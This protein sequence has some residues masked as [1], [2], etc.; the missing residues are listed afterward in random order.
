MDRGRYIK[1]EI[2]LFNFQWPHPFWDFIT[3][4]NMSKLSM[5]IFLL[6]LNMSERYLFIE[7]FCYL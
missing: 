6:V 1:N 3:R 7:H 5:K 2:V 4:R